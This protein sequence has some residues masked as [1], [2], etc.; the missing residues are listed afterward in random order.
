M[1]Q[2]LLEVFGKINVAYD[3]A[4]ELE[5]RKHGALVMINMDDLTKIL[6]EEQLLT[7]KIQ[8]L[9]RQRGESL[10]KLSQQGNTNL[11]N[12]SNICFLCRLILSIL[13]KEP[14]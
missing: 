13:G 10:T 5:E 1:W 9:E 2:N 12:S 8:K 6:D 4:I 7:S 14:P 11:S 3:K